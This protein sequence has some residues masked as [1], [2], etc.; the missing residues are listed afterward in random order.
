[1]S[2]KCVES[3]RNA[4]QAWNPMKSIKLPRTE[5]KF[6]FAHGNYKISEHLTSYWLLFILLDLEFAPS[7]CLFHLCAARMLKLLFYDFLQ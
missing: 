2:L 4:V 5:K 6:T 3:V 7:S 1:M